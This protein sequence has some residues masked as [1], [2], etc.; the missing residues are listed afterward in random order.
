MV[1][2]YYDELLQCEDCG[3][4]IYG[5]SYLLDDIEICEQCYDRA[6]GI[7]AI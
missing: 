2:D 5:K 6:L 1:E 7:D 3:C 4:E